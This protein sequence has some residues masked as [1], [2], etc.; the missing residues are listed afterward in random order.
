MITY[1]TADKCIINVEILSLKNKQINKSLY[2]YILCKWFFSL[3]ILLT[4][5]IYLLSYNKKIS[6]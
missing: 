2:P 6:D 3:K 4:F 1:G 5:N